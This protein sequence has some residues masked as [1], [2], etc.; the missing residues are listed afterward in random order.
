MYIYI[1]IYIYGKIC[2]YTKEY[3]KDKKYKKYVQYVENVYRKIR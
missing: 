1:Y 3:I 2:E